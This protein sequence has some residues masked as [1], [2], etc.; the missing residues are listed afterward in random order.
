MVVGLDHGERLV[1]ELGGSRELAV[2][3]RR[4]LGERGQRTRLQVAR[5]GGSRLAATTIVISSR[6]TGSSPSCDAARAAR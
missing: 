1:G 2:E 3:R 5:A 6:T 4:G